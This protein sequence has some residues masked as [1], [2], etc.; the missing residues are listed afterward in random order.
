MYVYSFY[1]PYH[2]PDMTYNVLG[3]TLKLAPSIN[4]LLIRQ[5]IESSD[6]QKADYVQ[7]SVNDRKTTTKYSTNVSTVVVLG[8]SSIL[9]LQYLI[10]YLIEY[11]NNRI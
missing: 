1:A 9:L 5:Y 4:V 2:V 3:G 7:Q 8:L 6:K 11:S 10:E